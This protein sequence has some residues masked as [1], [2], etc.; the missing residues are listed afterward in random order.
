MLKVYPVRKGVC[1]WMLSDKD[2]ELSAPSPAVCLPGCSLAF[3][4]DDNGQNL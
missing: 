1:F 2:G 4:H 3:H